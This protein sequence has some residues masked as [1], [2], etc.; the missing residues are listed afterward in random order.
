MAKRD[1]VDRIER[2]SAAAPYRD[3]IMEL[4]GAV[5]LLVVALVWWADRGELL[6]LFALPI[7]FGARPAVAL[8]KNRITYPR[9][10]Y[11]ES[12]NPATEDSPWGGVAFIALGIA[13]MV[14][15]VAVFDNIGDAASWRRW[16]PFLA[17]FLSA[18]GFWYAGRVSRLW[19]YRLV[20]AGSVA[21]GVA[22]SVASDGATYQHV[23][24]YFGAMS[25]LLAVLGAT[26]IAVFMASH[27]IRRNDS[28]LGA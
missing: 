24:L 4:F 5:L 6:A 17:G 15:A 19:R 22:V 18:A 11:A 9:I 2:Q 12:H 27:P 25:A 3:G 1:V 26:T 16:A 21:L 20:A 14:G 8:A 10:G 28:M 13:L 23:A 7:I